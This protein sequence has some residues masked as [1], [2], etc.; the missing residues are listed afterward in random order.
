MLAELVKVHN[1]LD[2]AV[3]KCYRD[4]A[5]GSEMERLEY[6][7]GLYKACTEPLIKEEKKKRRK[8]R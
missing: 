3:G 5:F 4:K 6:L 1:V 8:R 7:F 2:R